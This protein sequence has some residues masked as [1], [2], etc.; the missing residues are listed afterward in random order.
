MIK[1]SSPRKVILFGE[2]AILFDK[3]GMAGAIN[4]RIPISVGFG[5]NG[6]NIIQHSQY[7]GFRTH[8]D[9]MFQLLDRFN[10]YYKNENIEGIRKLSFD[11][12]ITVVIG[13]ILRKYGFR[14]LEVDI[15]IKKSLKGIGQSASIFSGI[16]FAVS[17]LLELELSNKEIADIALLGDIIVNG[18]LSSGIDTD[19]VI[20]GGFNLFTKSKELTPLNVKNEIPV[21]IVDSGILSRN[22]ITVPAVRK[23]KEEKTDYVDSILNEID[24]ISKNAIL[25]LEKNGLETIGQLMNRNHNLLKELGVSNEKIEEIIN[26]AIKNEAIGAKLTAGGRGGCVIVLAREVSEVDLIDTFN[27]EGF[28]AF[29]TTLG[30]EG[31]KLEK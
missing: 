24:E 10:M 1:V 23:L 30:A 8:R 16:T 27:N 9:E 26:L 11:D 25:A 20:N 17:K 29:K 7:A 4:K 3:L 13:K 19:T 2:Y 12:A 6:V 31:V 28:Y 18:G 22:N 14:D 21:I 15:T 5:K